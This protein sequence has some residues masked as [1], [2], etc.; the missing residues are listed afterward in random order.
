MASFVHPLIEPDMRFSRIRLSD[1]TSCFRPRQVARA[2]GQS[3]QP[4]VLVQNLGGEARRPRARHLMFLAQ[5]PAQ[6]LLGAE[7]SY[8]KNQL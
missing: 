3:D 7:K 8:L 4:Q 2:G 1:K 6:P 5:P